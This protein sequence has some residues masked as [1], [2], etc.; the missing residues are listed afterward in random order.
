MS[1]VVKTTMSIDQTPL[2]NITFYYYEDK[3]VK[4]FACV[5]KTLELMEKDRLTIFLPALVIF[6]LFLPTTFLTLIV[7]SLIHVLNSFQKNID[8]TLLPFHEK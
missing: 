5:E 3:V 6:Y 2:E 4:P 1:N 7:Y 8:N